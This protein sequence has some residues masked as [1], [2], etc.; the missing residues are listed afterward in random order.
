MNM[1]DNNIIEVHNAVVKEFGG[2]KIKSICTTCNVNGNFANPNL[3]KDIYKNVILLKN[4]TALV[5]CTHDL[6]T[7]ETLWET[8]VD[9]IESYFYYKDTEKRHFICLEEKVGFFWAI[10]IELV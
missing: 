1:K 7:R 2:K 3:T 10:C 4:S 9:N 8:S 5:F 6:D